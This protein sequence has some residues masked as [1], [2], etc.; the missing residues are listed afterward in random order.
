[1]ND[2]AALSVVEFGQNP[3]DMI[4]YDHDINTGDAGFCNPG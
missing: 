1:M 4:S 3:N 2:H